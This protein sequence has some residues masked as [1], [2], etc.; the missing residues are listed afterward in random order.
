MTQEVSEN[1]NSA[2]AVAALQL[3]FFPQGGKFSCCIH[4]CL[5]EFVEGLNFIR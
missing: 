1:S 5:S 4:Y 3:V 2:Q